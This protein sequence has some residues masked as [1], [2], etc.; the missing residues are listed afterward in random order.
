MSKVVLGFWNR[1]KAF[2]AC[3]VSGIIF[4]V[5]GITN[6]PI[7]GQRYLE[8]IQNYF[9]GLDPISQVIIANILAIMILIS[10]FVGCIIF[11]SSFLI[12]FNRI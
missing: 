6:I 12:L 4:L 10:D 8:F 1:I 2:L 9:T 5:S 3:F 11:I 7:F